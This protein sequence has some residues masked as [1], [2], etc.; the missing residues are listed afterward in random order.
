MQEI[1]ATT[2]KVNIP[3]WLIINDNSIFLNRAGRAVT[4][5]NN[6]SGR[7][8][9]LNKLQG[10]CSFFLVLQVEHIV[11]GENCSK[12]CDEVFLDA[13]K[14]DLAFYADHPMS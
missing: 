10:P 7:N 8:L 1:G 13:F 4:Y 12:P 11:C 6:I 14:D 5:S 3:A 9:P 2:V